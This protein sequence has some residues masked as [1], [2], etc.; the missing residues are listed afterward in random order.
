MSGVAV[1]DTVLV[2]LANKIELVQTKLL[3]QKIFVYTKY[4]LDV[5]QK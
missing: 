4:L 5:D 2:V 1:D 3:R